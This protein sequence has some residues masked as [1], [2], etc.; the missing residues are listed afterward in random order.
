VPHPLTLA[1]AFPLANSF[2]YFYSLAYQYDKFPKPKEASALYAQAYTLKPDYVPGIVEYAWF[3]L[4]K[5]EFERSLAFIEQI[6]S[7]PET[8]FQYYLIKGKAL[9]GK[10]DYFAAITSLLKANTIYNSD[11]DLLGSLGYC[12]YKR[13]ENDKAIAVLKSAL[14]LNPELKNIQALLSQIEKH[15]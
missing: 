13:G 2:L 14:R 10:A 4:R 7:N 9:M 11:T 8:E 1:K 6:K 12:Y 3:L 15:K 5:G